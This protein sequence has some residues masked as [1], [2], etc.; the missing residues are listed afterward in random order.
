MKYSP[1]M[2][3]FMQT[4]THT[5]WHL[6]KPIVCLFLIVNFP[7]LLGVHPWTAE[8]N[9]DKYGKRTVGRTDRYGKVWPQFGK[10]RS[11][12]SG[13]RV[14]IDLFL[15]FCQPPSLCLSLALPLS[16]SS[17]RPPVL[18]SGVGLRFCICIVFVF[19]VCICIVPLPDRLSAHWN[20]CLCLLR[21]LN[22]LFG[23]PP[24]LA[25]TL[26][27]LLFFFLATAEGCAFSLDSFLLLDLP[28]SLFPFLPL[29]VCSRCSPLP[30]AD[31]ANFLLFFCYY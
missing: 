26:L 7:S 2:C 17:W 11:T 14:V 12:R 4:H 30:A 18:V 29:S 15:P 6:Q 21:C 20:V 16:G 9:G 27:F 10:A 28:R 25:T 1:G 19:I 24:S 22:S 8:A 13:W 5:Q 3:T 31:R 23:L